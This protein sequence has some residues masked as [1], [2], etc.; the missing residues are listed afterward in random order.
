MSIRDAFAFAVTLI[1]DDATETGWARDLN[2]REKVYKD[3]GIFVRPLGGTDA[4]RDPD[5]APSDDPMADLEELR[6]A[7]KGQTPPSP[8]AD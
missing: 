2:K 8:S 6:A 5:L 1:V 3:I 4:E 7:M